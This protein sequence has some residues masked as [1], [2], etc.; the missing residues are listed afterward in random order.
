M[1]RAPA[2]NSRGTRTSRRIGRVRDILFQR[3]S[4]L[5]KTVA[6]IEKHPD[7]KTAGEFYISPGLFSINEKEDAEEY[8]HL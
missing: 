6:D 2:K 4:D 3:S 7:L 1:K 5:K 8:F